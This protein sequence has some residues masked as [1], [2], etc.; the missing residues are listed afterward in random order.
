MKKYNLLTRIV[1][2]VPAVIVAGF[3]WAFI[4]L[5]SVERLGKVLK[6]TGEN[7]LNE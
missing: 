3:I 4:G 5:F 2:V 6:Q 7:L 1:L